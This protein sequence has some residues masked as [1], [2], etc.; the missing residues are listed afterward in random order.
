M[1]WDPQRDVRFIWAMIGQIHKDYEIDLKRMHATGFSAG[2]FIAN[3]IGNALSERIAAIAPVASGFQG[4]GLDQPKRGMS[5]TL[6]HNR[7]DKTMIYDSGID[8]RDRWIK[9]NRCDPTAETVVINAKPKVTLESFGNG[10]GRNNSS[11][12]LYTFHYG[13]GDGPVMPWEEECGMNL[14]ETIWAFFKKHSLPTV[15]IGDPVFHRLRKKTVLK[16]M[17]PT[18]MIM[19]KGRSSLLLTELAG[20]L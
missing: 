6:I 4:W 17:N 16:L 20:R 10:N 11:I 3:Y 14:G 5:V 9:W 8:A 13:K 7:C 15:Q 1:L 19:W 12:Y 18:K 2:G